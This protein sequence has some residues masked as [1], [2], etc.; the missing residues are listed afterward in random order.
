MS[1]YNQFYF[2]YNLINLEVMKGNKTMDFEIEE[3]IFSTEAFADHWEK[4]LQVL[5]DEVRQMNLTSSE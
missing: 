4:A 5:L 1:F 3:F 2:F